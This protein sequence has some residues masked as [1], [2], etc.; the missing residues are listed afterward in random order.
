[1]LHWQVQWYCLNYE[2]RFIY[3]KSAIKFN[4]YHYWIRL[5]IWHHAML[6]SSSSYDLE[7]K[8]LRFKLIDSKHLK[9]TISE[10]SGYKTSLLESPSHIHGSNDTEIVTSSNFHTACAGRSKLSQTKLCLWSWNTPYQSWNQWEKNC[11]CPQNQ[12]LLQS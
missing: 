10:K 7:F 6:K 4:L 2:K 3:T 5:V 1:M 11:P 9:Y 8:V 12:S